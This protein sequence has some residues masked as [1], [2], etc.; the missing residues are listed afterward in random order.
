MTTKELKALRESM[1]NIGLVPHGF[2]FWRDRLI[3][4]I[5]DILDYEDLPDSM[6][7]TALRRG[8]TTRGFVSIVNN[9]TYGL[10]NITGSRYG[11]S[12]YEDADYLPKF[13]SD[14][15]LVHGDYEIGVDCEIIYNDEMHLGF[16]EL[17]N[18]YAR[19]LAD[20][21]STYAKTLYL[22]RRPNFF[23]ADDDKSARSLKVAIESNEVGE[24]S[25]VMGKDIISDISVLSQAPH[26]INPNILTEQIMARNS[27]LNMF[28]REFG[29]KCVDEKKERIQTDEINSVCTT[30]II[31][32]MLD[33]QTECIKKVNAMYGTDIKVKIS[34]RWIKLIDDGKEED[35]DEA[36][37]MEDTEQTDTL[38]MEEGSQDGEETVKEA[39]ENTSEEAQ[40]V[41]E[42]AEEVAE[43]IEEIVETIKEEVSDN[44]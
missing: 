38:E 12:V 43:A 13:V 22:M 27:I 14:N 4:K 18:R 25:I 8:L 3:L 44:G 16:N 23:N 33:T 41:G 17:I 30:N 40:T 5:I 24:D 2:D 6:N 39:G 7:K 29:I 34:D 36:H 15:V 9:D 10:V 20:A 26:A 11:V 42:I 31:Y 21:D 35:N 19:M 28:M 37:D 1:P 32:N